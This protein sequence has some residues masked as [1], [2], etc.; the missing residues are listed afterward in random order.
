MFDEDIRDMD[1]SGGIRVNR[2]F[3]EAVPA[4]NPLFV[5]IFMQY[6][7]LLKVTPNGVDMSELRR[8]VHTPD[9]EEVPK[10][11]FSRW[12]GLMT[13]A[14]SGTGILSKYKK[15]E[16]LITLEESDNDP[17][18]KKMVLTEAGLQLA[19]RMSRNDLERSYLDIQNEG[20]KEHVDWMNSAE[21]QHAKSL[22]QS[23][24]TLS[25]VEELM[26]QWKKDNPTLTREWQRTVRLEFPV[27]DTITPAWMVNFHA[28]FQEDGGGEAAARKLMKQAG[29]QPDD[30][31]LRMLYGADADINDGKLTI[32]VY[33]DAYKKQ[34]NM[35]SIIAKFVAKSKMLEVM[36]RHDWS[37]A[38]LNIEEI[39]DNALNITE[40]VLK[41]SATGPN[42]FDVVNTETGNVEGGVDVKA[43]VVDPAAG[44]G[45]FANMTHKDVAGNDLVQLLMKQMEDLKKESAEREQKLLDRI[46][47]LTDALMEKG[48][49]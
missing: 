4:P 1:F 11:T 32:K 47:K 21:M 37:V 44:T 23:G 45:Q 31:L 39:V 9:K 42:D 14:S 49:G 33:K 8:R 41:P 40:Y 25:E 46:D 7:E 36:K 22:F 17:R 18:A 27:P 48:R 2:T 35:S 13:S 38:G 15:R 20:Y 28:C 3:M 10:Q 26:E 16:P 12:I 19:R 29:L 24:H 5:N 30:I 6:L 34:G 43:N